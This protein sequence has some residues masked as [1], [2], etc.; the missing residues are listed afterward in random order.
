MAQ[1]MYIYDSYNSTINY[2]VAPKNGVLTIER[3]FIRFEGDPSTGHRYSD[4]VYAYDKWGNVIKTTRYVNEGLVTTLASGASITTITAYDPNYHTYPVLT[5]D[6]SGA[7]T[8]VNFDY[9]LGVPIRE[10]GPGGMQS[11]VSATY[12]NFGRMT[13]LTRPGDEGSSTMQ[14]TYHDTNPFWIE[15]SQRIED[16]R[17]YTM[18]KYY[19]GLGRVF[20]TQVLNAMVN[21]QSNAIISNTYYDGYGRAYKQTVPY[22]RAS[23]SNYVL[24]G[25]VAVSTT[26]YDV[27]GRV[28]GVTPPDGASTTTDYGTAVPG[29][30]NIQQIKITDANGHWSTQNIDTLG[31]V[32]KVQPQ[33]GPSVEYVYDQLGKLIATKYADQNACTYLD[34]Q[35]SASIDATVCLGYDMAGRKIGMDDPD[36]G[37]ASGE[38][39]YAWNYTYDAAG[40]LDQQT[41]ARG[42]TTNLDYDSLGRLTGKTYSGTACSLTMTGSVS[43]DFGEPITF[44]SDE[45]NGSALDTNEWTPTPTGAV[46]VSSGQV[47]IASSTADWYQIARTENL[48]L[49]RGVRFSFSYNNTTNSS[50]LLLD[51]GEYNTSSYRRLAIS[52]HGGGKLYASVWEGTSAYDYELMTL[53]ANVTYEGWLEIG[54][55]G[56]LRVVI[57][58]TNTNKV[59]AIF[60]NVRSNWIGDA[61]NFRA[62]VR[63]GTL[64]LDRFN[65]IGFD[66]GIGRRTSMTDGSGSTEWTYDNRGRL[67]SET[68][69]VTGMGNYSTAWEYNSADLLTAMTY[70]DGEEVTYDYLNQLLLDSVSGMD[71]YVT[72]TQYDEAARTRLRTLGND[73]Q[74]TYQY[75]PWTAQG[76]SLEFIKT[77]TSS[78]PES[79]QKLE[80]DYDEVGNINWIKNYVDPGGTQTSSFAYDELNRLTQASVT[81]GTYGLYPQ[82][83][84]TYDANNG[85]LIGKGSTTLNYQDANHFHAVSSSS[86]GNYVYDANGNMTDRNITGGDQLDLAYDSENRL[87]DISGDQEANYV[88]DGDGNMVM[89]EEE[90]GTTVRI[91]NYFEVFIPA[92][93]TPIAT[94]SATAT[95]TPTATLTGTPTPTQTNTPVATATYTNTATATR[96]AT[97]TDTPTATA[98]GATITPTPTATATNTLTPTPT[99]TSSGVTDDFNRADSTNLG[100]NWIERS[101]DWQIYSQTLRNVSTGSDAVVTYTGTYSDVE[102]SAK[103]KFSSAA[104]TVTIGARLGSYS[105]GVPA[106]GYAAEI[107][108]TGLVKLWRLSDWGELGSY[109]ISNYQASTYTTLLISADGNALR[110]D[111][112]GVTRISTTDTTFSSGSVGLWSYEATAANQHVFDDFNLVDLS[113]SNVPSQS[114]SMLWANLRGWFGGA[115][116]ANLVSLSVSLREPEVQLNQISAPPAGQEWHSYY[117]AGTQR[118]AMRIRTSVETRVYYLHADHLGSTS[119]TT[120]ESGVVVSEIRYKAWGEVRYASGATP[121]DYKF[122]GQLETDIGIYFY[123]ARFYDSDLGRFIQPDSIIPEPYNPLT[124]DR[125]AYAR[126][127]S[128]RYIDPLGHDV[129]CPASNPACLGISG[130]SKDPRYSDYLKTVK[131]EREKLQKLEAELGLLPIIPSL[132]G[133]YSPGLPPKP[134]SMENAIVKS[135]SCPAAKPPNTITSKSSPGD[136][137]ISSSS[138]KTHSAGTPFIG[139][140]G[141]F[142]GLGNSTT[143]SVEV[144]FGDINAIYSSTGHGVDFGGGANA[145][146]YG[147]WLW[148][149][150][151]PEEYAGW[152]NSVNLTVSV[153]GAGII[154]GVIYGD[155]NDEPGGIFFGYAPGARASVSFSRNYSTYKTFDWR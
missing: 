49:N 135:I 9:G 99:A 90:S 146:I 110:V 85:N 56:K 84:Y 70:P 136:F 27:F 123:V 43:Y 131:A 3:T 16:S 76:G 124:L 69:T 2:A 105:G 71:E 152:G 67:A 68:K 82:E 17:Y 30:E 81:G 51:A 61:W 114:I 143:G 28:V 151:S 20:E 153:L 74:T 57:Y 115:K 106:A 139:V 52:T 26:T 47:Q 93:T 87:V 38:S 60:S 119:L 113:Q 145:A 54:S 88:Y 148:A 118:V 147:G 14:V 97:P 92:D 13:S 11:Q 109:Q 125:Y 8:T 23:V 40:N 73:L 78:L 10:V 42:C 36:M 86:L 134:A 72:T 46:S 91:G 50:R 44:W 29:S 111:I 120:N 62:T 5:I 15:V 117:Y 108:N 132:A 129:G 34:P 75:N 12:D 133:N 25:S 144:V 140:S 48:S 89:M 6:D 41:D 94:Q 77:G 107:S 63:S 141:A 7:I 33:T 95:A 65:E 102:A 128:I 100:G 58:D 53:T 35:T 155:R 137:Q 154:G 55:G 98:T 39:N 31:Q 32:V 4:V 24:D 103:V 149:I 126:N 22:T 142:G 96:T 112:D 79:L 37:A 121:T 83:S 116:E 59:A 64:K 45:F 150:D 21:G 80:Y 18:R 104:G 19:D 130:Y 127:N 1:K 66:N 122:T 101:G 138:K